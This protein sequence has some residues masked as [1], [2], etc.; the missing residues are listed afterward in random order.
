MLRGCN[1]DT[2]ADCASEFFPAWRSIQSLR[3]LNESE[4]SKS[5]TN[6]QHLNKLELTCGKGLAFKGPESFTCH[7]F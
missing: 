7:G 2:Q 3:L 5:L 6:L 1:L 4:M